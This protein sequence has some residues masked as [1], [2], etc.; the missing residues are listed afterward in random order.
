MRRRAKVTS[1][2]WEMTEQPWS[3]ENRPVGT[4]NRFGDLTPSSLWFPPIE[5]S[6][7]WTPLHP[8][9]ARA[10]CNFVGVL[11]FYRRMRGTLSGS[12]ISLSISSISNRVPAVVRMLIFGNPAFSRCV[13]WPFNTLS[14]LEYPSMRDRTWTKVADTWFDWSKAL[15]WETG[16]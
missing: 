2:K 1:F 13:V 12:R 7:V 15:W 5:L 3:T 10:W 8:S 9:N 6:I 16:K 11:Y 14:S 4:I